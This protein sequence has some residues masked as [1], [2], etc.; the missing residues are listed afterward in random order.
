MRLTAIGKRSLFFL[1]IYYRG[2]QDWK[3]YVD[4]KEVKHVRADYVLRGLV[5]PAGKHTIEFK[6]KPNSVEIG[7]KLD[8]AGSILLLLFVGFG[9][10][11][12][13]KK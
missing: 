3:A 12:A 6:F 11:M 1:K 2:N 9:F 7:T 5:I 8:A 10:L 13:F 4:G